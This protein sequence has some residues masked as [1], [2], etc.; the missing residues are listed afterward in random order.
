M[1]G[2][3]AEQ[4]E[5]QGAKRYDAL[6]AASWIPEMYGSTTLCSHWPKAS[7]APTLKNTGIEFNTMELN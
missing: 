2:D 7:S 5:N 1:T 3:S 6:A 4:S